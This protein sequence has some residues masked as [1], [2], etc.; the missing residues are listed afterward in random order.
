MTIVRELIGLA[1][2]NMAIS[3]QN[4]RIVAARRIGIASP[5]FMGTDAEFAEMD[6]VQ[7]KRLTDAMAVL[8]LASPWMFTEAQLKVAESVQGQPS[9]G[10][11]LPPI[12]APLSIIDALGAQVSSAMNV[13]NTP[14]FQI[15]TTGVAVIV[16]LYLAG[17]IINNFK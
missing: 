11:D 15:V 3:I 5:P 9:F 12:S 13:P 16:A 4:W 7:K 8:A 14:Q 2:N 10:E 17:R 1:F 6:S